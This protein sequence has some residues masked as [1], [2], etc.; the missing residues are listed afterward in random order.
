MVVGGGGTSGNV[1]EV[2]L[3]RKDGGLLLD[4]VLLLAAGTGSCVRSSSCCL[5]TVVVFPGLL[6]SLL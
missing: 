1:G 3:G 5:S 4:L 2:P 6:V